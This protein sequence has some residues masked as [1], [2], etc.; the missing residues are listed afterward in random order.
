MYYTGPRADP[1]GS[2]F[3]KVL[4]VA[5]TTRPVDVDIVMLETAA[6]PTPGVYHFVVRFSG[7]NRPLQHPERSKLLL[8]FDLRVIN[9]VGQGNGLGGLNGGGGGG[10]GAG[11]GGVPGF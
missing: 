1:R 11:S 6:F 7:G 5:G 10:L 2:Y 3:V 9:C 4:H 8:T